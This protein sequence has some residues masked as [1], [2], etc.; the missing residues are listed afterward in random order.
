MYLW[1]ISDL[2]EDL[3]KNRVPEYQIKMYYFMSPL[4]SIA[5]GLFFTALLFGHHVVDYSFR[6]MIKGS[7]PHMTFYNYWAIILTALTCF[8][9]VIG[10]YFCY[11]ANKSGDNKNFWQ[12]MACLS[13]PINFHIII[14]TMAA[15]GI[16]GIFGYFLFQGKIA[17]FK[18]N[19]WP[20]EKTVNKALE[21]A[22][23]RNPLGKIVLETKKHKGVIGAT[24]ASPIK[25]LA[26]PLIPFKVKAFIKDLR[27]MTLMA[28]PYLSV[29]PVILSA[30]HYILLRNMIKQVAK[31]K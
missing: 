31:K 2:I 15:L 4:L 17:A 8:I 11:R 16:L 10:M 26:A 21:I 13:F 5:N 29:L 14:Y 19:I 22:T 23:S 30:L 20:V 3:K 18:E 27:A 24:L 1:D 9:A 6:D 7:H 28:Y 12:R 25:V